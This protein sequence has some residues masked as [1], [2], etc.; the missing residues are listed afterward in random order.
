MQTLRIFVE[1]MTCASCV[2]RVE[3]ALAQTDGVAS[4]QVNLATEAAEI[5]FQSPADAA[6]LISVL[7]KA[8]YPARL[9]DLIFD[10]DGMHCASC[11]AR[12]EQVLKALDGVHSAQVNLANETVQLT[13]ISGL[14]TPEQI[15][16]ALKNTGYG[17]KIRP[18]NQSQIPRKDH[19][20]KVLQRRLILAVILTL[21][22]FIGE[23]GAHLIPAFHHWFVLVVPYD[24]WNY[25]QIT[26]S[27]SVLAGPGRIFFTKGIPSLLRRHPDMNA[28]VALGS[29]TAFAYSVAVV[30]AADYLPQEAQGVYFEAAAVI[31]TLILLGRWLEARAKSRTG[32]A[33]RAL[34]GLRAK[35]ARID[36]DGNVVEIP[37]EDVSVGDFVHI[38]P[39]EK[40]A[41]DGV[42]Q[43]GESYIDESMISG[44]PLPVA[45]SAG[46]Q[47]IAGTV[48]GDGALVFEAQKIGADT[49]LSQIIK[50]VEEA[51]SAKLPVQALVDRVTMIFVPV[52]LFLACLTAVIWAIFGPDP[53]LQYAFLTGISV[54]IIACPCAMGLATPTSI[55]VGTGRAAQ[56]GVLFRKGDALQVLQST[57]VLAFDKTGTLTLGRPVVTDIQMIDGAE[58]DEDT[59]LAA[60]AAAEAHSEHP[61]A[62]AIEKAAQ[63]RH[64]T[65]PH[66]EKTRAIA[67]HGVKSVIEGETYLIG[68]ARFMQREKINMA[69]FDAALQAARN[70]GKTPVF[71]AR[72]ALPCMAIAVSDPPRPEAK[73]VIKR[74]HAMGLKIA[75]ISGDTHAAATAIAQELGIDHVEAEVLPKGKSLAVAALRDRFGAVAFVGDGIND[76]PALA[77]ADIGIAIG[78]GTDVAIEAA[79]VVL[80]Q[81]DLRAVLTAFDV[82]AKTMRNIRQN[83]FWAFA[84]N[85]AL[86]PVA[87]G[88]FYPFTGLLLSPMI[89]AGAMAFSSVFVVSNALR[90]RAIAPKV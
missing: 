5:Q 12:V 16:V 45:K 78:S 6:G 64:L 76:A 90:L 75:M 52:V 29:G 57:K 86:I 13:Y 10:L 54:L 66:V 37:I 58:C 51:Q 35:T 2:G 19:E 74:L 27:F 79:D 61:I 11:V 33:I 60:V 43:R 1:G 68:N 84:Y 39:G 89:G 88:V 30:F 73:E 31:V 49:M 69:A 40:I 62:R 23:M 55:M 17:A 34:A 7:S 85:A 70:A 87:A 15:G 25:I 56:L 65:L 4:A 47:V 9:D 72:G 41:V 71:V 53:S 46:A 21:P 32:D 81:G 18:Q 77:N 38:R 63:A 67:G 48:N 26:L 28:L 83:L 14:A 59:V 50:M 8:G 80:S 44:E 22:I 3:Q 36:R 42:V 20:M 82:S 24:V